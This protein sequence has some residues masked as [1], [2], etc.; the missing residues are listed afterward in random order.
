MKLRTLSTRLFALLACF[1][2]V[3]TSMPAALPALVA[4]EE[5]PAQPASADDAA[6]TNAIT[7]KVSLSG[8]SGLAGVTITA[9]YL[10]PEGKPQIILLPGIMGTFLRN[11][12]SNNTG[13][14]PT[15]RVWANFQRYVFGSQPI[16]PLLLNS[17]GQP[18]VSSCS[19]QVDGLF[20]ILNFSAPYKNFQDRVNGSSEYD[21][22][23]YPGYDWRLDLESEAGRLDTWITQNADASRPVW[24]VGHSMGG[25]LARAYVSTPARA[26]KI[27]GVVTVGTP[28]LGAPTFYERATGGIIGNPGMDDRLK[29]DDVRA[30]I[31]HAPGPVQLMPS[32]RWFSNPGGNGPAYI[33]LNGVPLNDSQTTNLLTERNIVGANALE[34]ALAYHNNYG[35]FQDNFYAPGNTQSSIRRSTTRLFSTRYRTLESRLRSRVLAMELFRL[36]APR[37]C[38]CL[39]APAQA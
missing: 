30:L 26:D 36:K 32:S 16:G 12:A 20:N 31:R 18:I 39:P 17:S 27:A 23:S 33:M 5:S 8:G 21:L 29:D 28:Y 19:I 2:L 6:Q 9:T 4:Q 25:L 22:L 38:D 11:N 24:L 13:C 10:Q 1:S 35:T 37:C 34:K 15:G 7:G 3:L 14:N